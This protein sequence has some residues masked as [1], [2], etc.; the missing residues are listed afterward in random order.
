MIYTVIRAIGKDVL[1]GGVA[2]E[3]Q[4][5]DRFEHGGNGTNETNLN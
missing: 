5:H 3:I 4:E 1:L 2:V